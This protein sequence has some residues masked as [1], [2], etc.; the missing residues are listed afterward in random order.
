MKKDTWHPKIVEAYL[1]KHYKNNRSRITVR[2]CLKIFFNSLGKDPETWLKQNKKRLE[3]DLFTVAKKIENRPNKTQVTILTV[4]KKYLERHHMEM[5]STVWE[6]LRR[7][8]SLVRAIRPL[9]KKATPTQ[10]DLKKILSFAA[11]S[12]AKSYVTLLACSGLR[13]DEALKLE[14]NDIDWE[15][16]MIRVR[17]EVAKGG[18]PRFTFFTKEAQDL[19]ELWKIERRNSLTNLYRVSKK[20]RE[21]LISKG[22]DVKMVNKCWKVFK[23]GRE[24]STAD[25][26]ELDARIFPFEFSNI[27][28]IWTRLLEKTGAPYNQRDHNPRLN[29]PRYL[30]N[31]N[32]I[33]R[34][35]FTQLRSDRM[36]DEFYNFIGGHM[37]LLDRTYGD[38]LDDVTMQQQ[39]KTEYDAH[40]SALFISE[41]PPNLSDLHDEMK[42]KDQEITNLQ[43]QVDELM[44]FKTR[45]LENLILKHEKQIN[46]ESYRKK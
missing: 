9:S 10:M 14:W 33:R 30:Y 2:V 13:R 7:R 15:N 39:I 17:E 35:W 25:V 43:Q 24:F 41:I 8:N 26:I 21:E 40:V 20:F 29:H 16:H 31:I 44:D 38:W 42:E 6:E 22:Y 28:K 1:V 4:I 12:K 3:E 36:N 34:F 18:I 46:G 19:L 32:S 5:K 45:Y 27:E 11:N 23:D 37:S